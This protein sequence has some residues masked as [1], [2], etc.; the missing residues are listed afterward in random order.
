MSPTH[1]NGD[2]K[3][4]ISNIFSKISVSDDGKTLVLSGGVIPPNSHFTDQII[5]STTDGMPFKVGVDGSFGGVDRLPNDVRL[6][7]LATFRR[8]NPA[9][10]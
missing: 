7:A 5:S 4:G 1:R 10:S 9:L 3:M 6:R 2:G 8:K